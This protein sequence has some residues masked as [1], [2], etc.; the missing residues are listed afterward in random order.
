M[1]RKRDA[2][3][4]LVIDD[5]AT[6][7]A[8]ADPLRHQLL[9]LLIKPKTVRELADATG[10]APD[11]LY[12]H[13]GV[14]EKRGLVEAI[15]ER[16]V[17][18]RYAATAEQITIDPKLAMPP[19]SVDGV[20][21]GMLQHA[22]REYSAAVRKKRTAKSSRRTMLAMSYVVLTDEQW[23]EMRTRMEALLNEYEQYE[24]GGEEPKP[25]DGRKVYGVL[26]GLWPASEPD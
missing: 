21:T 10:R 14:L 13:L 23:E 19:G 9:T 6:L 16:G 7:K 1:G 15:E 2:G 4:V 26:Q 25:E 12:Y 20:I 22:Q 8:L 11:R 18:R 17:E 24:R 3:S 5:A